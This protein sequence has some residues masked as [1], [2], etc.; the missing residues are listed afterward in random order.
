VTVEAQG[1]RSLWRCGSRGQERALKE[2]DGYALVGVV[3]VECQTRAVDEDGGGSGSGR[4][5]F[6]GWG[7]EWMR[8][9]TDW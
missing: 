7:Q 3:C 6:N 5:P 2:R 9:W 4:A 1:H 8:Y